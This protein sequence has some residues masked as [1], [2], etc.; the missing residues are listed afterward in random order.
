MA[1][2]QCGTW[3]GRVRSWKDQL[4]AACTIKALSCHVKKF[5]ADTG[6]CGGAF[7]L[8]IKGVTGSTVFLELLSALVEGGLE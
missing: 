7:G 3:S 1:T 6:G 8:L 4:E 5:G 2:S